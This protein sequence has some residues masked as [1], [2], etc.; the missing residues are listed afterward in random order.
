MPPTPASLAPGVQT[1]SQ[2]LARL[3]P[4]SLWLELEQAAPA[5]QFPLATTPLLLVPPAMLE[6]N[7]QLATIAPQAQHEPQPSL[8]Q[9]KPSEA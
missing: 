2:T 5:C 4:G 1:Q 6:T 3:A 9:K 7:V 8:A